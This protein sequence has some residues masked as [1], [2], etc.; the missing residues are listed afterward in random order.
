MDRRRAGQRLAR[1]QLAT[2]IARSPTPK[3]LRRRRGGPGR[4]CEGRRSGPANCLRRSRPTSTSSCTS[5]WRSTTTQWT[6]GS[7]VCS[8]TRA[9]LEQPGRAVALRRAGPNGPRG[10][11]Q[12]RRLYQTQHHRGCSRSRRA[13]AQGGRG[14]ISASLDGLTALE[15]EGKLAG[16]PRDKKPLLPIFKNELAACEAARRAPGDLTPRCNKTDPPA[17]SGCC[18]SVPDSFRPPDDWVT[19]RH[20]RRALRPGCP[21]TRRSFP[22]RACL[23]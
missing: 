9:P 13:P 3:A 19:C 22:A 8:R 12:P 1:D 18:A 7:S 14:V 11:R 10:C 20:S 17:S 15:R 21:E 16:R 23:A 5:P 6:C 4:L 2:A